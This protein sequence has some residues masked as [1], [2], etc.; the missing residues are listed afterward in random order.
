[1]TPV[2][3]FRARPWLFN[4][5]AV[6]VLAVLGLLGVHKNPFINVLFLVSLLLA[7]VSGVRLEL[8]Y[9]RSLREQQ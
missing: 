3:I 6:I 2:K 7:V 4:T 5:L 9:R 1:M 8:R